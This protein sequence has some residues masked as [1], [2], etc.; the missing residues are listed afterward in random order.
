MNQKLLKQNDDM[1]AYHQKVNGSLDFA[2]NIIKKTSDDEIL[3]HGKKIQLNAKNIKNKCPKI[4]STNVK[5][6][7]IFWF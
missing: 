1:K 7:I 3:L 5:I 4:M 2:K 6:M